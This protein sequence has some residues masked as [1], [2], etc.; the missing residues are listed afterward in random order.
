M[1]MSVSI[2]KKELFICHIIYMPWETAI[3][4]IVLSQYGFL[5]CG[6]MDN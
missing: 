4:K 2:D 6:T 5:H 1:E 3:N